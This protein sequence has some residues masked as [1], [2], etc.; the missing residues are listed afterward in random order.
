MILTK[1]S[2][3]IRPTI[4]KKPG[5]IYCY[6]GVIFRCFEDG[7]CIRLR[8]GHDVSTNKPNSEGRIIV[9]VRGKQV[10]LSRLLF[11]AFVKDVMNSPKIEVDHWD[12]NPL[13]NAIANLRE[14]TRAEN[15]SNQNLRSNNTSGRV[16]IR[17]CQDPYSWRWEVRVQKHGVPEYLYFPG[18]RGQIPDD[19]YEHIPQEVIDARD[20]MKARLH[21]RFARTE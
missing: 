18:G 8:D 13:N 5:K 16:G 10:R 20:E 2:N 21:G 3:K 7:R 6:R 15:G 14:A 11:S 17:A 12:T 19:V 4:V 9:N 1:I